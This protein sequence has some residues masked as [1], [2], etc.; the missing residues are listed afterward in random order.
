MDIGATTDGL[1]HIS[2]LANEYV[3]DV[4]SFVSVGQEVKVKVIGVEGEGKLSLSMKD[5]SAEAGLFLLAIVAT[6]HC[7]YVTVAS[8]GRCMGTIM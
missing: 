6:C 5:D 7:S 8:L 4:N 2:Q 1:V 3:R